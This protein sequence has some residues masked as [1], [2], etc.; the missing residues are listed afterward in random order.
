MERIKNTRRNQLAGRDKQGRRSPG[1]TLIEA[2]IALSIFAIGLLGMAT[3][4]LTTIRGNSQAISLSRAVQDGSAV[5][6]RAGQVSYG[7]LERT[8][9]GP[10][11]VGYLFSGA[12]GGGGE[13]VDTAPFMGENITYVVSEERELRDCPGWNGTGEL[14]EIID[15]VRVK[16]VTVYV[17]RA[18]QGE[19]RTLT[20]QRLRIDL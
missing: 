3:M 11:G 10:V 20:M 14:A 9:G 8:D 16:V 1:F 15:G 13:V 6:N 18:I 5:L 12:G 4:L 17:N 19:R 7:L 2:M